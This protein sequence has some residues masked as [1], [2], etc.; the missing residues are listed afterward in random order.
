MI[1]MK[2][3]LTLALLAFVCLEAY[4]QSGYTAPEGYALKETMQFTHELA[5]KSWQDI[6]AFMRVRRFEYTEHPNIARNPQEHVDGV[7]GSVVWDEQLGKYVFE[8][9]SHCNENVIDGDR[10]SRKDRMRN[11]MKSQTGNGRYHM[12]GNW[13]EWQ[14]I[15]WKLRIPKGYRPTSSFCHI[16]QYKAQEGNNGAPLITITLRGD[17]DGTNRRV[18]LIHTGDVRESSVGVFEDNHPLEEFED[19]WVQV[20][21]EAHF[22]RDGEVNCRITRLSDGKVLMDAHRTGLDMWRRGATNIRNKFGIYRSWGSR[23][24]VEN[25]PSARPTNGLKDESIRLADFEIYEKNTNP[26]PVGD[27][28]GR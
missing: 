5:G 18:Q 15:R 19:E 6:D 13:D 21:M 9:Y 26:D 12:N 20:E 24:D 11:E 17:N 8:V 25:D 4:A 23:L 27:A 3:T 7:H 22:T 14:L 16:F 2:K 1:E 28:V 10:G